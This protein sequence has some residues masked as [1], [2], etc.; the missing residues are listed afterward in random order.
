MACVAYPPQERIDEIL[1]NGGPRFKAHAR[2]R[3]YMMSIADPV[4]ITDDQRSE[5]LKETNEAVSLA[6]FPPGYSITVTGSSALM[7]PSR[8]HE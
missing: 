8:M 2:P 6:D 1:A 7:N 5:I 4:Y 3:A